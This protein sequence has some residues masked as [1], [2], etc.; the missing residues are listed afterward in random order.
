MT[1]GG[2]VSTGSG[3]DHLTLDFTNLTNLTF[4]GGAGTGDI[5]SLNAVGN[6]DANAFDNISNIEKLDIQ[7]FDL[8]T[9]TID[10]AALW[11]LA[12]TSD[13]ANNIN[14]DVSGDGSTFTMA[15]VVNQSV[16]TPIDV[17]NYSITYNDETVDHTF[18]LHVM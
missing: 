8:S 7:S 18:N 14:L 17:S 13:V 15:N 6:I 4:N 1:T 10:A 16:I 9:G 2:I 5:L 11:K 3:D 12:S